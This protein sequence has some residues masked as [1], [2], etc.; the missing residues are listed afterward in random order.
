M[1][2]TPAEALNSLLLRAGDVERNQ[3]P[4][5][6]CY[7]CGVATTT[8]GSECVKCGAQCHK[9]CSSLARNGAAQCQWKNSFMC[10][11]C[12]SSAGDRERGGL[13]A[14]RASYSINTEQSV[15]SVAL[16]ATQLTRNDREKL[17]TGDKQWSCSSHRPVTRPP[18]RSFCS[19]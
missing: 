12:N 4:T 7:V 3:G 13:S 14:G 6:P 17:N 16:P 19:P 2:R 1:K 10:N 11:R 9:K 15:M 8:K 18:P 5:Q